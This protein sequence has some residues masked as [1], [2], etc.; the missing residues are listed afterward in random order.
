MS[1]TKEK[2]FCIEEAFH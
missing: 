1:H 2:I